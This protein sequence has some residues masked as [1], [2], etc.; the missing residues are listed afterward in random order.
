MAVASSVTMLA[1]RSC[2]GSATVCALAAVVARVATSADPRTWRACN[3]LVSRSLSDAA[4]PVGGG[5]AGEQYQRSL[6]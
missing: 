4:D 5:V 2:P 1:V 6:V 3:Q